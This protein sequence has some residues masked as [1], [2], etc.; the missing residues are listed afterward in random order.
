MQVLALLLFFPLKIRLHGSKQEP[1]RIYSKMKEEN[2][3][4]ILIIGGS[5]VGIIAALRIR[6]LDPEGKEVTVVLADSFTNFSIC[7]PRG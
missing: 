4:K 2:K 1:L 7:I 5:D 3:E 6:E